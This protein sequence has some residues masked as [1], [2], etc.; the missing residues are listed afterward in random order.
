MFK[1]DVTPAG[2]QQKD[3]A[4]APP[5]CAPQ[6]TAF[7]II[8]RISFGYTPVSAVGSSASAS[9]SSRRACT[10]TWANLLISGT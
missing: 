5:R 6:G 10:T 2:A 3:K 4:A 7:L 9:T 1:T 8:I